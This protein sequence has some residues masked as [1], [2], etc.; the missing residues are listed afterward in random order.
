MGAYEFQPGEFGGLDLD[1]PEDPK[2]PEPQACP[3]PADPEDAPAGLPPRAAE[4]PRR[5][6]R[7]RDH[8]AGPRADRRAPKLTQLALTTSRRSLRKVKTL[9]RSQR[10]GSTLRLVLDETAKVSV[11][12][13][14]KVGTL[15]SQGGPHPQARQR[16]GAPSGASGPSCGA[17]PPGEYRVRV[18][19]I[20]AAANRSTLRTLSFRVSRR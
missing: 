15:G 1:E 10:A 4:R 12:L 14:R 17:P 7:R 8:R 3:R 13:E 9:R 5:T 6:A 2:E 20:D 18:R 11:V 19:A 16:P